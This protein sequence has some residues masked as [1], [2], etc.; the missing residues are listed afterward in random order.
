MKKWLWILLAALIIAATL[1]LATMAE[2]SIQRSNETI[3]RI[4]RKIQAAEHG[5]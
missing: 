3:E 5:R 2:T 4:D 1:T